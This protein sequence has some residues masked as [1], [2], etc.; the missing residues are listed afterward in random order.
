LDGFK[1]VQISDLHRGNG[2]AD[3]LVPQAV[4]LANAANADLAVV[5]G[6]F[7]DRQASDTEPVVRMVQP[8][9]AKL[10]VYAVLGNHDHRGAA[11]DLK[12][13][14]PQ[15]G[16]HLLDNSA[17]EI[18]PGFWLAGVDDLHEGKPDLARTM[19]DVPDSAGCVLLSHHPGAIDLVNSSRPQLILSG[20][21][22]GG[23]LVLPFPTP[24]M[25]CLWH[26]RTP[27][28]HGWYRNGAAQ[29]YVNR[30]IGVT[31]SLPFARRYHCPP[32]VSIFTL[33]SKS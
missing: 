30:G 26:L 23:Q 18:A 19:A 33:R 12:R 5:T 28:V 6:D 11:N 1:I 9:R 4:D 16:I 21:T 13:L 27:Y 14:I 29:L 7:V 17:Q 20:H 15:A 22:H 8:L 31:G 25:V 24:K 32:E 2:E 3:V 10:G